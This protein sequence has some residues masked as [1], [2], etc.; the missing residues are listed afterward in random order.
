MLGQ[1]ELGQQPKAV[2]RR[3]CEPSLVVTDSLYKA[4][5][6]A[7]EPSQGK[8][9][10]FFVQCIIILRN[11]LPQGVTIDGHYLSSIF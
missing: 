9:K 7:S 10:L 4:F 8:E 3:L 1:R 5:H 11:C 6:S 2:G